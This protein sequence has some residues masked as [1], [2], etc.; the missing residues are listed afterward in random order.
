MNVRII[1][2]CQ[3]KG[4]YIAQFALALIETM[5][6]TCVLELHN[7]ICFT[8]QVFGRKVTTLAGIVNKLNFSNLRQA[9]I[10]K[11]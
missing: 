8:F 4:C 2:H 6:C 9:V 3:Q 7:D 5:L 11:I 1:T 10:G